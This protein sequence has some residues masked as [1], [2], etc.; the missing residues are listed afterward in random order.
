[1]TLLLAPQKTVAPAPP[2]LGRGRLRL[3]FPTRT[4]QV[5]RVRRDVAEY[6]QRLGWSEAE[7]DEIILAVGEAC[8]NAV[9]YGDHPDG[10]GCVR[11][12]AHPTP[13]GHLHIE[14]RNLG[15]R[16][17]PNLARLRLLPDAAAVHGRGF[18]LMDALMDEVCVFSEGDKTIVRLVKKRM[19]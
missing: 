7:T 9:C 12:T 14:I 13:L 5:S 18:A 4:D 8:N 3:R 19:A 15:G 2:V 1:M 17:T 6:V 16:F 10:D 11:L